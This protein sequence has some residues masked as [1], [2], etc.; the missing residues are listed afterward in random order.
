MQ[1]QLDD[2]NTRIADLDTR[3]TG[4][5]TRI[6]T[7]LTEL[8]NQLTAL[9][10]QLTKGLQTINEENKELREKVETLENVLVMKQG[11]LQYLM[12]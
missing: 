2:A 11:K 3:I 7:Q 12:L 8:S 1:H 4:I 9:S 5:N 10:T 6:T